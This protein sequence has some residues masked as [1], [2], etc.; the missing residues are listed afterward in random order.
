MTDFI[1][2]MLGEPLTQHSQQLG[3]LATIKL[4]RVC[5][6]CNNN[7]MSDLEDR[8]RPLMEPLIR[9][10]GPTHPPPHRGNYSRGAN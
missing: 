2:P 8:T 7:W 4:K 10:T 1:T 3:N 9:D 5:D 6:D